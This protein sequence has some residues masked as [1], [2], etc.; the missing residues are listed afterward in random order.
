M[1]VGQ[2]LSVLVQT[3]HHV[4]LYDTGAH[5]PGGF[6]VGDAIVTPYLRSQNIHIIDRLEISHGDNDHSGGADAVVRNFTVKSIYTSAP[7]LVSNFNARYC[8]EGQSWEWDGVYFNTFNPAVGMTYQDNNSSCV[9]K[10]VGEQSSVLLTGDIEK[11]TEENLVR[12]FGDALQ[13]TILVAPHHG[14][15]TSSSL[16]F[17]RQIAP[18]YAIISAGFDN[19]YHFPH[20]DTLRT[21]QRENVSV[22]NTTDCGMVSF[23]LPKQGELLE[24]TCYK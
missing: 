12:L 16:K 24:P 11:D 22:L 7:N 8:E 20:Q 13:A 21:L 9:I 10:I 19:R 23:I 3:A 15:K 6:D 17:I 2:G 18:K 4:M 14:S 5:M 1:E